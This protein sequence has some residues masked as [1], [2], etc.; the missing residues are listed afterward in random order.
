M[1]SNK[2]MVS[3]VLVAAAVVAGCNRP[4]QVGT[5]NQRLVESLK[6]AVMARNPD[7][8]GENVKLIDQ[9]YQKGEMTDESYEAFQSIIR[10]ANAGDWAAAQ[11]EVLRLSKVQ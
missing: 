4:P 10:Q 7:W 8:L 9:R 6:T 11:D 3:G 2:L 5:S 1:R